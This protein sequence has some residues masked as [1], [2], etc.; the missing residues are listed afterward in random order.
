MYQSWKKWSFSTL[1]NVDTTKIAI[2]K[3]NR[4]FAIGYLNSPLVMFIYQLRDKHCRDI[5][6]AKICLHLKSFC[7]INFCQTRKRPLCTYKGK[8]ANRRFE[9]HKRFI[10]D[11]NLSTRESSH[12]SWKMNMVFCSEIFT[13]KLLDLISLVHLFVVSQS[14][15]LVVE[16][17]KLYIQSTL[18]I[19]LI[20][21]HTQYRLQ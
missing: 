15:W 11:V 14:W 1:A 17:P 19:D 2:F 5:Q 8:G 10:I 9:F 21:W 3:F 6:T 20:F 4:S 7:Q 12:F 18:N 16:S 13:I